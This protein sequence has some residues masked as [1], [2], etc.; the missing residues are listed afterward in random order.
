MS[1]MHCRAA[2]AT[3]RLLRTSTQETKARYMWSPAVPARDCV[4][5]SAMDKLGLRHLQER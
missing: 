3:I 2:A 4:M 1:T 5:Q